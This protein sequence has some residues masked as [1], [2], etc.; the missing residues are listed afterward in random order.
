MYPKKKLEDRNR[1]ARW[2]PENIKLSLF[3]FFFGAQLGKRYLHQF[4]FSFLILNPDILKRNLYLRKKPSQHSYT[5]H[6]NICLSQFSR[7][8]FYFAGYF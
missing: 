3:F 6:I 5:L 2:F 7:Q 1:Y 4:S 8:L